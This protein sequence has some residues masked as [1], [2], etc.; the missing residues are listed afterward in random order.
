[1]GAQYVCGIEIDEE[2]INIALENCQE[3]FEEDESCPVDLVNAEVKL[4]GDEDCC[5]RLNSTFDVV[6]QLN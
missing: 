3:F 6:C 2:A 5:E 1:M 4:N